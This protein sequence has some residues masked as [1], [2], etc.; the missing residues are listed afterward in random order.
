MGGQ[1][2]FEPHCVAHLFIMLTI[3]YGLFLLLMAGEKLLGH[4]LQ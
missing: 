2:N 4:V 3:Y 1:P